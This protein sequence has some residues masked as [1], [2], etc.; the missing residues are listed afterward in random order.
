MERILKNIEL[1]CLAVNINRNYIGEYKCSCCILNCK[2][3]IFII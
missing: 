3:L 1:V 2:Y